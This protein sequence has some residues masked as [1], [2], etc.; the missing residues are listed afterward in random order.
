MDVVHIGWC[1]VTFVSASLKASV[2]F[3]LTKWTFARDATKMKLQTFFV[4]N[5]ESVHK[6]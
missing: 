4:W 6:T 3:L 5:F 1:I 2:Q